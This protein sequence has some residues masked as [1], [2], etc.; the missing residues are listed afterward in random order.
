MNKQGKIWGYTQELFT[1]NNVSIHRIKINKDSCCSKHY[2]QHK[3]NIFYVESGKILVKEWKREYDLLDETV[4]EAGQM[5]SVPPMNYHK[6]VGL[7]DSVVYEIYYV[8]LD[9]TDIIRE[10]VGKEK[11]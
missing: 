10:D 2:H 8:D 11:L 1:K 9:N 6:F 5:C 4:L 3:H 7:E